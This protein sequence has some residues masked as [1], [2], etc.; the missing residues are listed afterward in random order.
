MAALRREIEQ[1]GPMGRVYTE[2]L[3]VVTLTELVR[4]HSNLAMTP[5]GTKGLPARRL[6]RVIDYIEAH[7]GKDLSLLALAG[8][9]GVGPAHLAREFKRAMGRSLHQH[10]LARRVEWAAAMLVGTEQSIVEIS[11]ATGFS[12]QT[13]LTTAFHRQY[14][15][16]PAAYRRERRGKA[17]ACS[18]R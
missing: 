1:P 4:R 9:A 12:S 15:T 18:F 13:H 17:S 10:L 6:R 14:R 16:T 2:S 3:V 7:L 8:E 11:L 5:T